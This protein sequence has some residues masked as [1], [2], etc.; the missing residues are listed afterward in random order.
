[1]LQMILLNINSFVC[2]VYP[3]LKFR[4]TFSSL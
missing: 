4:R 3:L 1:M 2:L